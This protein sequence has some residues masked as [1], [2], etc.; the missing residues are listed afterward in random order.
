MKLTFCGAA[1]MVTGSCYL[2]EVEGQKSLVDCG[3]FQ[4]PKD[5]MRLNFEPFPF[6]P[7]KI[8]RVFLTHAHIDHSG[9]LPKLVSAGFKGEI[10]ATPATIDL[11]K[12]MLL[13]SAE[14]HV[15]TTE[16][17]NRRR[18]RHGQKP[19]KPLYDLEQAK[20]CFPLFKAVDY[21]KV[22]EY[23][24]VK[25]RY[26]DAG[27]IIGSAI[28][29]LFAGEKKIVFS[30]DLGEWD[31]PIVK[32]PT[33]IEEADYLLIESTYGDRLHEDVVGREEKLLKY[34]K[35]THEAGGKLMI[36]SFAVERT[37]EL[38][39]TIRKLVGLGKFP[40][41]PVYLDSPLAIKATE[42]F[43][44]HPECYDMDARKSK[45]PFDFPGLEYTPKV[46]DSMRLN[47]SS[48]P[49]VVIAGN[50]M[51][52]AGRIRHHFKHGLWN[53][54]N[55]VLFVGYQAEGTLGRLLLEGAK[56]VRMMGMELIVKAGVKKIDGFSAHS[57][58]RG[59]LRWAKG[60]ID[61][62]ET[63]VVHGESKSSE[64]LKKKLEKE[65]FRCH[66]PSRGESVEL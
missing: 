54:K 66:I 37:Q 9:L 19:R 13:D 31:S 49:F 5:I 1:Q 45:D 52:T 23:G 24:V 36:P 41:E 42:V 61:R 59:L 30:G 56:T 18:Q 32:D 35:E 14:I 15:R 53:P 34:A 21:D 55:T 51:A 8:S 57:D 46:K 50:G 12:V 4:G 58:Y 17:E 10:I 28:I 43:K 33:L 40:K 11:C 7:K 63:F 62:P 44:N 16:E 38:L 29:E 2:L 27:H 48:K 6:D 60:F 65:G 22:Y 64:S 26:Q 25:V 39:Y 3:M 47:E 20:A